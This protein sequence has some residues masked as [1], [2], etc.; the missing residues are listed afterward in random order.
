MGTC[1]SYP[2]KT[3]QMLGDREMDSTEYLLLVTPDTL[4]TLAHQPWPRNTHLSKS[5]TLTDSCA[6]CFLPSVS[7]WM[8]VPPS[9]PCLP[10]GIPHLHLEPSGPALVVVVSAHAQRR[11]P[12]HPHHFS[13]QRLQR[14][15]N[16]TLRYPHLTLP[17]VP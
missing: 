8:V 11:A 1:H 9:S 17:S 5:I 7:L 2:L 16:Y 3:E 15:L 6:F 13:I 14:P 4:S 10:P 12:L